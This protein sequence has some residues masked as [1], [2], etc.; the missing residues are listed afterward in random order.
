MTNHLYYGDNLRV[1]RDYIGDGSVD[2]IYLDPEVNSNARD[3]CMKCR[4]SRF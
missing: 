2:L 1:L 3:T 4:L